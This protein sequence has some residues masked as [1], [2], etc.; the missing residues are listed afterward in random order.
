MG[1]KWRVSIKHIK[2]LWKRTSPSLCIAVLGQSVDQKIDENLPL[3]FPQ[4]LAHI[5]GDVEYLGYDLLG[6]GYG[7]SK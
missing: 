3:A 4:H 5:E 7:H 2:Y 6:I 1:F